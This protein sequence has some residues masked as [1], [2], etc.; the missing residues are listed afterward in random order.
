ME[1]TEYI[2][3]ARKWFWLI[4]LAA[5][6][7]GGIAFLLRSRQQAVY[8]ANVMMSVGGYIEAPNPNTTEI[9]T[10][11]RLAQTYAVLA[12]TYDV[13]DAVIETG[14]FPLTPKLL[15]EMVSTRI[16]PDTSLLVLSISFVDP[17]MAADIA[18]E[19]AQQLIFNSPSNLTPEQQAQVDLAQEEIAKLTAE[20]TRLREEVALIDSN[21]EETNL[22]SAVED[23]RTQRA[24]LADQINQSS[25]NL[26]QFAETL[27]SLQQRTNSLD[28]VEAARIPDKPV[29]TSVLATTFLGL[30]VGLALAGGGHPPN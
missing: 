10:G 9:Y 7:A 14:D 25:A 23:L 20:L 8:Q 11:E 26:A 24:I 27:T 13:L 18:N 28:I 12:K 4:L 2:R 6:L 21:L 19:L 30:V 17:V 3:L 5:V 22:P 16:L 29:G 15:E 1:L